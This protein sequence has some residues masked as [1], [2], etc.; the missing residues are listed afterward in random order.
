MKIYT[1]SCLGIFISAI[2]TIVYG[3]TLSDRIVGVAGL[4]M[5]TILYL[6]YTQDMRYRVSLILFSSLRFGRMYLY[7][8]QDLNMCIVFTLILIFDIILFKRQG[9]L[10]RILKQFMLVLCRIITI[11]IIHIPLVSLI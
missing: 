4:I 5:G 3:P 1:L 2:F 8:A 6:R 11:P 9:K 7:R 10:W